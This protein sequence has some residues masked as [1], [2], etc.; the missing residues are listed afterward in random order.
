M[1]GTAAG[2]NAPSLCGSKHGARP[3]E[4]PGFLRRQGRAKS[5]LVAPAS[6]SRLSAR[7]KDQ[8]ARESGLKGLN[9][10]FCIIPSSCLGCLVFLGRPVDRRPVFVKP[11]GTRADAR[12]ILQQYSRALYLHHDGIS[13]SGNRLPPKRGGPV[14][15]VPQ[16]F[17]CIRRAQPRKS[18]AGMRFL[19]S[20]PACCTKRAACLLFL[21]CG[22]DESV[23]PVCGDGSHAVPKMRPS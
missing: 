22:V 2:S 18:S 6:V 16:L 8:R 7:V 15:R 13:F 11:P 20:R 9:T 10:P 14:E 23:P 4:G 12:G 21:V 3:L 17:L 1:G 19:V 5:L